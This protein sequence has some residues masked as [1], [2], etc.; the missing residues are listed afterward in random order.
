[1]NEK[2]YIYF[3]TA[4]ILNWRNLL[5][6]DQ[7]RSIITNSLDYLVSNQKI[8]IYAFV[9]MPSHIHLVWRALPPYEYD[10]IH[11][12]FLRFTAHRFKRHLAR[13]H[14]RELAA[15]YVGKKDREY[16][17]WQRYPLSVELYSRNVISQKINYIHNNPVQE[18][19]ALTE[20]PD[21]Y[22]FS[23]AGL[24]MKDDQSWPFLMHIMEDW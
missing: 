19:E 24:Y 16:Q 20:T 22:M 11:G 10:K 7:Y 9:V 5:Q 17:F 15:F 8:A 2:N 13:N 18:R 14:P 3:F 12:D 23:S 21:Q 1:M 4:T 6:Y